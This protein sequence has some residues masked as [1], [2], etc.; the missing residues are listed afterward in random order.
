M[1]EDLGSPNKIFLNKI[2][3]KSIM[4]L[5]LYGIFDMDTKSWSDGILPRIMR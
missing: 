3:P 2:N 5:Q 1:E 4:I